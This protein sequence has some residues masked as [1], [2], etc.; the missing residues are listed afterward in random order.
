MLKEQNKTARRLCES[1]GKPS[2]CSA[3]LSNTM[4]KTKKNEPKLT[5]DEMSPQTRLA[6]SNLAGAAIP[7]PI[8]CS[9]A[10]APPTATISECCWITATAPRRRWAWRTPWK[11]LSRIWTGSTATRRSKPDGSGGYSIDL[12]SESAEEWKCSP[13]G[14]FCIEEVAPPWEGAMVWYWK[15]DGRLMIE[16][17]RPVAEELLGFAGKPFV[18]VEGVPL[19]IALDAAKEHVWKIVKKQRRSSDTCSVAGPS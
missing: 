5:V 17:G 3:T 12:F 8:A 11:R 13:E 9:W 16:D 1:G 4:T 19:S 15:K 7:S 10:T 6:A 18:L 14:T 2:T